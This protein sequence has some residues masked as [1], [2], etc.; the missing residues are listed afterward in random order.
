MRKLILL[1]ITFA[2]FLTILISCGGSSPVGSSSAV[3]PGNAPI[4]NAPAKEFKIVLLPDTQIYSK[5]YPQIYSSQTQWIADNA[6][7]QNIKVVLGLGD[8]V[9]GGGEGPQWNAADAA[10]RLLDNRVPYMLAMGNHDY[11]RND[12]AARTSH[13]VNFNKYFGPARYSGN[14]WYRGSFPS[15]SNENFYGTFTL[16]G[17]PFLVLVLEPFPRDISLNWA[18]GVLNA[19]QDKDVIIVTHSFTH[20]DNTRVAPGEPNSAM[21]FGVDQDN[22]GEEMWSK[23]VKNYKNVVMVVSGHIAGADGVGRLVSQGTN[24]NLVNQMLS[25]YQ[26]YPMGGG[27]FLRVLTFKLASNKVDVSTFSPYLNQYK[28]DGDNQFTIQ[29]K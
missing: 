11:D 18:A 7:A 4:A 1:T 20:E 19:N 10:M 27:G 17:K 12:P 15:G 2:L 25:D 23:F 28:T 14:S 3:Q 6:A 29:Y 22:D 5:S 16:E 8:I 26:S 9:D 21:Y 24:G 13:T